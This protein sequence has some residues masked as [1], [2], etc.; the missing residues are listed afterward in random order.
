MS[1]VPITKVVTHIRDLHKE[2]MEKTLSV[3]I[4]DNAQKNMPLSGP[5][6][7]TKAM[8]MYTHL[9]GVGGASTRYEWPQSIASEKGM[10]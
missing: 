2:R 9:T 3:W 10:V 5:L 6:I 8:H 1:D 4:E 7:R